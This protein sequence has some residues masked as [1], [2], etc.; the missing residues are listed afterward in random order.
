M[1]LGTSPKW[2]I[3]RLSLVKQ[4]S[5]FWERR[6][7]EIRPSSGLRVLEF[8]G[9]S[10]VTS[11]NGLLHQGAT[12]ATYSPLLDAEGLVPCRCEVIDAA[13]DGSLATANFGELFFHA[14]RWIG[15][16]VACVPKKPLPGVEILA[17]P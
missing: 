1:R 13:L 14:L 10:T 5:D 9:S 15:A 8:S 11:R 4:P 6:K 7:G 16:R 2:A 17:A 12:T 3:S